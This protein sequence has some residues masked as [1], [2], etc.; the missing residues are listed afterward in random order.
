MGHAPTKRTKTKFGVCGCVANHLFHILSKSVKGLPSCEGPK[1][2]VSHWLWQSPLQQVSA[3]M[4]PMITWYNGGIYEMWSKCNLRGLCYSIVKLYEEWRIAKSKIH[5][6]TKDQASTITTTTVSTAWSPGHVVVT[7]YPR[8]AYS[9]IK[10]VTAEICHVNDLIHVLLA[11]MSCMLCRVQS[12]HLELPTVP[13]GS[14]NVCLCLVEG[15]TPSDLTT[16]MSL[17]CPT[18]SGHSESS[19][20]L[21]LVIFAVSLP[22]PFIFK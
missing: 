17:I 21:L 12:R 15:T 9:T 2:A 11:D 19:Y 18:M 13:R 4:L 1:I 20:Y 5:Y 7:A 22:N 16:C 10:N 6:V 3:T 8:L 14:V